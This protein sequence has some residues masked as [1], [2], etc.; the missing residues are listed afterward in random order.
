MM[1]N[2][3]TGVSCHSLDSWGLAPSPSSPPTFKINVQWH[4]EPACWYRQGMLPGCDWACTESARQCGKNRWRNTVASER[5]V[6]LLCVS[7]PWFLSVSS[8]G[9]LRAGP[10]RALVDLD[11]NACFFH[12]IVNGTFSIDSDCLW[13]MYRNDTDFCILKNRY[14]WNQKEIINKA[15]KERPQMEEKGR[16]KT[17]GLAHPGQLLSKV[18]NW[19]SKY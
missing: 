11:L 6:G 16:C 3:T 14:T 7:L 15:R 18:P 9:F 10:T 1:F 8:C 17:T 12:A 19:G 2:T 5:G 13:L 4:F